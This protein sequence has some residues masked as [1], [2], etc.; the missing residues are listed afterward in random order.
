MSTAANTRIAQ[1]ENKVYN[2]ERGLESK[3]VNNATQTSNIIRNF[4]KKIEDLETKIKTMEEALA[5]LNEKHNE[6][7][8][9]LKNLEPQVGKKRKWWQV[10]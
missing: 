4:S 5:T 2:L 1:L 9:I 6:N 3:I 7:C 8:K 10:I